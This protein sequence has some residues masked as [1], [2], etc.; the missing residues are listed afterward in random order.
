MTEERQEPRMPSTHV[1]VTPLRSLALDGALP[2]ALT[3]FVGRARELAAVGDLLARE[4]VRLLTIAGA[5]GA[6]KTRLAIRAGEAVVDQGEAGV[7]FVPL[8]AVR[9]PGQVPAAIQRSIG[10]REVG[11]RSAMEVVAAFF[12]ERRAV[13]ILDNF[14]PVIDAGPVVVDLLFACPELTVLVTS[15]VVLGVSGEHVYR[16]PPLALPDE[17]RHTTVEELQRVEAVRLFVDRARA[18]ASDFSLTPANAATV[19]EISRRLDGLPLA[20]ELAAA[21]VTSLSPAALLSLLRHRLALLTQGPRDAPV[22]HQSM[23]EAIA[24][25]YDLLTPTEQL[26]FRRL[27]VFS[28]GFSLDAAEAVLP[29]IDVIDIIYS[30]VAKSLVIVRGSEDDGDT[31]YHMLETLREFAGEQ[32]ANSGEMEALW[33]RHAAYFRA[34]AHANEWGWFLPP[35][36]GTATVRRIEASHADMI[37]ALNWLWRSHDEAALLDMAGALVGLWCVCGHVLEGQEWLERALASDVEADLTA[38]GQAIGALS[39]VMVQRGESGR[40]FALAEQGNALLRSERP[41]L[42]KVLCLSEAGMAARQLGDFDVA[43]ARQRAAMA[44]LERIDDVTLPPALTRNW[45]ISLEVGM[46]RSAMM[47]GDVERASHHYER[48]RDRQ[49]ALGYAPGAS[50]SYGNHVLAGLGDVARAKW[51]PAEALRHYRASLEQAWRSRDVLGVAHAIGGIAGTFAV[52]G[53]PGDAAMLFGASEAINDTHGYRFDI[54]VL[55]RQ[56]ALGLPEPWLRAGEPFGD[57]QRLRDALSHLPA[58]A[59]I[60]DIDVATERWQEGRRMPIAEAV[61]EALASAI[62]PP[63]S[64]SGMRQPFG[65][66]ERELEVLQLL[67]SGA[68]DAAIAEVLYI[69][70]RTA[71]THV[72]HIYDKLGVSSRAAAAAIAVRSGLA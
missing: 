9:D 36:E 68:S 67:V 60:S 8:V 54:E 21:R 1:A 34:F 25:S 27:A 61:R 63:V 37:A 5:G 38:R 22:R 72:R 4:D 10:L 45:I 66:T 14:E 2:R 18:S 11:G 13:L 16:V 12:R 41:T 19:A 53:R 26:A 49:L 17:G 6:G 35:S 59:S 57:F 50:H 55:D 40:A 39:F 56:R 24:W 29:D 70:R 48:A 44:V 33:D 46:G 64:R 51:Q 28:G 58:P 69:S 65:L 31:R 23:R 42:A 62:E 30:L 71:A 3:S 32:L 20:I 7:W 47:Q 52:L 15:R 43:I